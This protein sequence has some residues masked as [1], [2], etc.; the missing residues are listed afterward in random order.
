LSKDKQRGGRRREQEAKE[1][2]RQRQ[3]QAQLAAAQPSL[4][5]RVAD[6]PTTQLASVQPR[7]STALFI[8]ASDVWLFRDG[9]P[10]SAGSDRRANSIFPPPPT[11]TAGM[12]RTSYLLEGNV[13]LDLYGT[14]YKSNTEGLTDLVKQAYLDIGSPDAARKYGRLRLRGPYLA[15]SDAEGN[16][17]RYYPAPA[18]L[19]AVK[20]VGK[21]PTYTLPQVIPNAGTVTNSPL[22]TDWL[23][24]VEKRND[25]QQKVEQAS[26]WLTA[27]EM[28]SYLKGEPPADVIRSDKLFGE[29]ERLGIALQ[30]GSKTTQEGMLYTVG[31]TRLQW[32]NNERVGL[33]LEVDTEDGSP[34]VASSWSLQG[35]L[36]LGGERRVGLYRKVMQGDTAAQLVSQPSDRLKVYFATPTYFED[37]WQ[38]RKGWAHYF[39]GN[40]RLVAA[41]INPPLSVGGFDLATSG[42]KPA[43]RYVPAGSV[44]YL[45]GDNNLTYKGKL[46]SD[47]DDKRGNWISD[48]DGEIGFG[49]VLIGVW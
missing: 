29:E 33:C 31:F 8:E 7:A 13:P 30:S 1:Q 10:F 21:D 49:Q 27:T 16:I 18:D 11:T 12:I 2:D 19:F 4:V 34:D 17:T 48:A 44:Y 36:S 42:H 32:K 6:Q 26:G 46:I 20:V 40:P 23:L 38:P 37:G 24:W 3:L 43:R 35:A 47:A 28:S 9:K 14:E 39:D 45:E 5:A 41:A 25:E 22:T 15:V